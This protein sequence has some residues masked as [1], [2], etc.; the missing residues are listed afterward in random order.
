MDVPHRRLVPVESGAVR[1]PGYL[2][3]KATA[4]SLGIGERSVLELIERRRLASSRLGRLHFIPT[5]LVQA[6]RTERRLRH[7]RSRRERAG[8][9]A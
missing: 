9:A 5:R 2:S 8:H 3:V 1:L 4:E 7:R 6:Y